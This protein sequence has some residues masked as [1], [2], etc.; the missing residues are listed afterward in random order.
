MRSQDFNRY[1]SPE[2][3]RLVQELKEARERKM[4]VVSEFEYRVYGAFDVDY[5]VWMDVVKVV[6]ELDC[7]MSLSKSSAALGEPAVRPEMVESDTAIIE[8]E[9][10]RHPCVLK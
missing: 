8:F 6:A 1:W 10:L 9:E 5:A 3:T 4:T 7:L 2:V